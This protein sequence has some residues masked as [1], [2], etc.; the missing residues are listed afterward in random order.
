[1]FWYDRYKAIVEAVLNLVISIV[2]AQKLG[3]AGIFIGTFMSTV[4][5][6]IWIEPYVLYK[7]SFHRNPVRFFV[8]YAVNMMMMALAWMCTHYCCRLLQSVPLV[9]LIF[10]FFIC[11][12]VPNVILWLIYRKN[13]GVAGNCGDVEKGASKDKSQSRYKGIM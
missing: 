12:V 8:R 4:L 7:Y 11:M 6:S 13:S 3:V 5:T 9:N 2:L 10:R 1:M